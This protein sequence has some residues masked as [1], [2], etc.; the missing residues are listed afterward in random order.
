MERIGGGGRA[1]QEEEEGEGSED[2]EGE[3]RWQL[4]GLHPCSGHSPV[5]TALYLLLHSHLSLVTRDIC[6][7]GHT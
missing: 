6:P 3:G 1:G 4:P 2:E 5:L 7:A